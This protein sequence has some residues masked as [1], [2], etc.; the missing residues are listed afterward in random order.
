MKKNDKG[1][2]L[3][4]LLV[5]IAI[6]GILA[7]MLLPSLASSKEKAKQVSCMNNLREIGKS[8]F[9][10][11]QNYNDY[12]PTYSTYTGA[13]SGSWQSK[14]AGGRSLDLLRTEANLTEPK[15]FICP[16]APVTEADLGTTISNNVS[17]AWY[18]PLRFD[19]R[20]QSAL[21]ADG[22]T[23]HVN[24]GRFLRIDMSV[25]QGSGSNWRD[26]IFNRGEMDVEFD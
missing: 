13:T 10:Y 6:I 7:G 4:E 1:F 19:E 20:T 8:A 2:T 24:S 14:T 17:Y 5:V 12:A 25:Q 18:E 26:K 23:N 9:S 3:I 16:S 22:L 15:I 21:A 11:S